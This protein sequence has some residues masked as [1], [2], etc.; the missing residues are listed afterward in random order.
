MRLSHKSS[1]FEFTMAAQASA[2]EKASAWRKILQVFEVGQL[3]P[4]VFLGEVQNGEDTWKSTL[5]QTKVGTWK[6]G[7][8]DDFPFKMVSFQVLCWF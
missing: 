8:E 6:V 3:K 5:P 1:H 4:R 7:V 2:C